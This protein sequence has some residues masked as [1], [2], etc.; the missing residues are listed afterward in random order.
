MEK[1]EA[2]F[3]LW[4]IRQRRWLIFATLLGVVLAAWGMR[5]LTFNNDNR[6]FFSPDNPQ[7]KALETLEN[8]YTKENGVLF[9]IAPK[10]GKVFT[11]ETLA[12]IEDLTEKAWTIPYTIRVDSISNYQ[13]TE[14][15]EDDLIVENLV[16]NAPALSNTEVEKIKAIALSEP[17]LV[18]R[19][20]SASGAVT[21]IY[22]NTFMP[23]K[24]M[25]EVKEVSDF[26]MQLA[27]EIKQ[28]HPGI[29]IYLT[30]GVLIDNA[31]GEA[32]KED[33][34]TLV[35]TMF[36]TL[37]FIVGLCLRAFYG[38]IATLLVILFSALTAM[39]IAGWIGVSITAASVNAPTIIL[40]LAVADSVHLLSTMMRLMR[41]GNTK[42]EAI[43]E[44]LHINL[45]AV[46][47]TSVTTAI[48]FL[49]MNFSDAPPFRDLGN[50]VAIG[51]TAAFVYSVLFLPALMAVLPLRLK[52]EDAE[53][54]HTGLNRLADFVIK[55]PN[56]VFWSC[57]LISGALA[58][59]VSR[60][61]LNDNF[62]KYFDE[63]NPVRRAT[64][65]MEDHLTGG[66]I[67]EYA[68]A[69][70]EESGINDP[71]YLAQVD[72]F[73]DWY[74]EQAKVTHVLTIS[75]ILKRLNQNMHGDDPDYYRIP[76]RRDLAAQYLL[77]YE[78]SLPFGLDL[79]NM[80]NV[81]KSATRMVVTV[82]DMSTKELQTLEQDARQWLKTNAPAHMQT[83][84]SGLSVIWANLAQRNIIS[85]LQA[86][87]GALILIAAILVLAL[88]SFK[89][90]LVSLLPNLAPAVV[91]FGIWGMTVGQI[92]LGLSVVVAM[93]LGIVVDDTVHF[94]NK[95][96]RARR[97]Q[98]LSAPE[99]VRHAFNT[100][101]AAMWVTTL[102]LVAGFMVLTLSSYRMNADMG[103]MSALTITLALVMDFLLLPSLLIK[104]K[105]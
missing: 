97:E 71:A 24:S 74:R 82:K 9:V 44:A 45:Q 30:G 11:Q 102:A 70:G 48:G 6:V 7:L 56:T 47:L 96:V 90:G 79:N 89:L 31:F 99:A 32:S 85:M 86:S 103:L 72:A 23:G 65:F 1:F 81:R 50:I 98:Q 49:S 57:L 52:I 8:T 41:R 26:A 39:G 14:V 93:T 2:Q 83:Y 15:D 94:L 66:D 105:A 54:H 101:G 27:D 61:E 22:A 28:A 73:A 10:D 3:G 12:A 43:A 20:I 40:T 80:I 42:H 62:V 58:S 18:N 69:S 37:I 95:Y 68:L 33:M 78:L 87:F 67:I 84:G 63:S 36:L 88:K 64:D 55:R 59:G 16:R 25:N 100:V 17:L 38:T 21:R 13:H 51:V 5:F 104:I 53:K 76:E 34:A 75:D 92:G 91:A 77:L 35:P 19:M 29:D 4:V 60:I 46:F